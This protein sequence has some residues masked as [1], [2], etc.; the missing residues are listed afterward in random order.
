MRPVLLFLLICSTTLANDEPQ[1]ALTP[2]ETADELVN[3]FATDHPEYVLVIGLLENGQREFRAAGMLS[4]RAPADQHTIFEI[5]SISKTFTATAMA[6]MIE[7][8]KLTADQTVGEFIPETVK[9]NDSVANITL[10]QLATHTSGL[11][12]IARTTFAKALFTTTPYGG[13]RDRLHFDL[14]ILSVKPTEHPAYSNLGVGLLG[15]ILAR[16]DDTSYETV[17]RN[18]ITSPLNMP[19][20][21]ENLSD[22]QQ[23]RFVV[24]HFGNSIAKP[25]SNMGTAAGAGGL[26]STANDMLTYAAAVLEAPAGPLGPAIANAVRPRVRYE[27]NARDIGLCWHSER[28]EAEEPE[29][30]PTILFHS[31]ATY[32]HM[33]ALYIDR[34]NQR[35]AVVLLNA[36]GVKGLTNPTPIARQ[37]LQLK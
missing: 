3:D 16:V 31:G 19:D 7:E 36:I 20:T 14:S 17:I 11:P 32:S 35:A 12:R 6:A 18:R 21:V 27:D 15:D 5:G 9:L 4:E 2:L 22:E 29:D 10:E 26:R 37:V 25:W 33:T 8:G 13:S 24:G 28:P 30:F 34:A 23:K 1:P